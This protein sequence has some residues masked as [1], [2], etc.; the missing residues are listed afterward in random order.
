MD[1]SDMS[2]VIK[3]DAFFHACQLFDE[4]PDLSVVFATTIIGIFA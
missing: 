3:R 1:P 4:T 2:R